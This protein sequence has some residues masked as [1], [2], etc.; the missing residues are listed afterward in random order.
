MYDAGKVEFI[1]GSPKKYASSPGVLRGFCPTCGTPLWWEGMWDDRAIEMV[2]TASLDDPEPYQP[3]RHGNC[4][5]Q[6]SWFDVED[7]LPR[8]QHSTPKN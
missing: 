6:I 8:Y 1:E 7:D 3:D 2:T 4:H 5:N